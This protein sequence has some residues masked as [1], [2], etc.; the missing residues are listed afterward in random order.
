MVKR[1]FKRLGYSFGVF[2][3]VTVAAFGILLAI[4]L[5][6]EIT[7][8]SGW[9]VV[10]YFVFLITTIVI[11]ISYLYSIGKKVEEYKQLKEAKEREDVDNDTKR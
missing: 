5:G 11:A 9:L 1:F 2:Y 8:V 6:F 7:E 4:A 10:L 3:E